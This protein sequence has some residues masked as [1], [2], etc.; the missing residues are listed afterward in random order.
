MELADLAPGEPEIAEPGGTEAVAELAELAPEDAEAEEASAEPV[1][2]LADL[3]PGEPDMDREESRA[4]RGERPTPA[5]REEGDDTGAPR[6]RT[7]AELYVNQ[8]LV[9]RAIRVYEHLL[10]GSPDD[11][12]LRERLAEL[13]EMSPTDQATAAPS[14]E[15]VELEDPAEVEMEEMARDMSMGHGD[16]GALESPFAWT[17]DSEGRDTEEAS[18][19]ETVGS[20]RDLASHFDALLDWEPAGTDSTEPDST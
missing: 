20:T 19:E 11:G 3:A 8:G 4:G 14:G 9:A 16:P 17:R 12:S 18:S 13:R 1:M 5:P 6:T 7:M 2:D 15:H 10:E